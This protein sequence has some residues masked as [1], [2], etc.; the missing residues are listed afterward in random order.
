MSTGGT[1]AIPSIHVVTPLI[2]IEIVSSIVPPNASGTGGDITDVGREYKFL[3]M[4]PL[5]EAESSLGGYTSSI[6][7]KEDGVKKTAVGS[8]GLSN[9]S[10]NDSFG[11]QSCSISMRY[12]GTVRLL[13]PRMRPMDRI[14][15]ELIHP[16]SPFGNPVKKWLLFDGFL[17]SLSSFVR[18]GDGFSAG[19]TIS[20]VGIASVL[21]AAV[22]NWQRFVHPDSDIFNR[23]AGDALFDACST[24]AERPD[25]MIEK[26]VKG[27][28]DLSMS[29]R[30]GDFS[31]NIE[32]APKKFGLGILEYLRFA[33]A[34]SLPGA[35]RLWSAASG[36]AYPLPYATIQSQSGQSFWS[37]IQMV[38][39]PFLH[40]LFV[41]YLPS[42]DGKEQPYLV[43]RPRPFPGL[44]TMKDSA[45]SGDAGWNAIIADKQVC[46]VGSG[47]FGAIELQDELTSD[48]RPNC[49][50]WASLGNHDSSEQL[51]QAKL[52]FGYARSDAMVNRF[53][54][55]SHGVLTKLQPIGQGIKADEYLDWVSEHLL[56]FGQQEVGLPY[57][58]NRTIS[59]PFLA[60]RPGWILE[61]RTLG[62]RP[63][64][65]VTGYVTSVSH[66][67]SATSD[68]ISFRTNV[69]VSRAILGTDAAGYPDAARALVPDFKF[70]PYI[71]KDAEAAGK[72]LQRV[73]GNDPPAAATPTT[74]AAGKPKPVL[75]GKIPQDLIPYIEAAAKRFSV[76][77][78]V[79]AHILQN[80]SSFGHNWSP[81]DKR[82]IMQVTEIANENLISEGYRN[83]NGSLYV[84]IDRYNKEFAIHA[85]TRCIVDTI[86]YMRAGGMPTRVESYW[87]W[88]FLGYRAG[89]SVAVA[90]G[91]ATGWRWDQSSPPMPEPD[92]YARYRKPSTVIAAMGLYSP[93]FGK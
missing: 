61:D 71:G 30:V 90:Y 63:E 36:A 21:G 79:I 82:G 78:W 46:I 86:A 16:D 35:S 85:G 93:Y 65:A 83:P 73:I 6:V 74:T 84:G 88:I 91:N 18:G 80:E 20:A 23:A 24:V 64:D 42:N 3:C 11:G 45:F 50:H 62:T 10:D 9:Y 81:T 22:F 70:H 8:C 5:G 51:F 32:D 33:K 67:L 87:S 66:N 17:R 39:E 14:R 76:P 15:V 47:N 72:H 68:G 2:R 75:P 58:R 25:S 55:S 69:Q 52:A 54:F 12:S 37:I 40:E 13:A 44:F 89:W 41:S 92:D 29:L 34:S 1:P 60:A 49:F 19:V 31:S 7:Y 53:G 27:A 43:H 28:V 26:I 4:T 38:S 59:A 56:N 57:M 48:R 77:G